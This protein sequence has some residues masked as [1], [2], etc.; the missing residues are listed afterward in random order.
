MFT[1]Y[2]LNNVDA[3]EAVEVVEAVET[4]EAAEAL[5]L[6]MLMSAYH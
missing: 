4:V 5:L 1:G 6:N 3:A 2:S